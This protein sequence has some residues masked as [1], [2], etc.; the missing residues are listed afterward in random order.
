MT[1][2]TKADLRRE[3]AEYAEMK[4]R[5]IPV[6]LELVRA[7]I[8]WR[9]ENGLTQRIYLRAR[10]EAAIDALVEATDG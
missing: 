9:K 2:H 4:A 10:L 3:Q 8:V 7:A 1:T 5:I 6:V